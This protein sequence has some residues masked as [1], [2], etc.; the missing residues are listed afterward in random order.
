MHV[1]CLH[2]GSV[3]CIRPAKLLGELFA[4]RDLAADVRGMHLG[5]L[6]MRKPTRS[7]CA[8][9]LDHVGSH[10]LPVPTVLHPL[11]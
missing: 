10:E 7:P 11:A 9:L 1:Q 8:E 4:V 5:R 2:Q 6:H 3:C